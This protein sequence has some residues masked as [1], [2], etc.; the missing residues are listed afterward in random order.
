MLLSPGRRLTQESTAA[1]L[2][3]SAAGFEF[4]GAYAAVEKV[5]NVEQY[6][7]VSRTSDG[8]V[9]ALDEALLREQFEVGTA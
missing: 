5:L 4:N 8:S 3:V 9:V 1:E 6:P 2:G 7:V